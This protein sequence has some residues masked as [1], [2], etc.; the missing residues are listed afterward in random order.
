MQSFINKNF[1]KD[2]DL[3]ID[4]NIVADVASTVLGD[5]EFH[6]FMILNEKKCRRVSNLGT[7]FL[8]F[9]LCP[10]VEFDLSISNNLLTGVSIL[11]CKIL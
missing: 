4:L 10:C 1:S 6:V 7:E 9:Q 8:N 2:S 11:W 5:R 3:S